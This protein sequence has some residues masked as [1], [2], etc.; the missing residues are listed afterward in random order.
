VNGIASRIPA[1]E[2]HA[3]EGL[4]ISRLKELKRSPKHYQWALTHPKESQPLTL[5]SAAH[6]AVLEPERF[7]KDY[8]V[9]ARRTDGGALAPR[10]GQWWDAFKAEHGNRT[11]ITADEYE[12]VHGLQGAVRADPVASRY[13]SSGE[14]EVVLSWTMAGRACRGRVDWLTRID[15]EPCIVGLKTARDC[16]PFIFGSAAAKLGYALQ[17]AWYF[18]G[19]VTVAGVKPRM[20]EIVVESA[21]P[22]AVV[23]Y[24][25][26]EDIIL[27]GEEE[28][29]RLLTQLSECEAADSWPGP[30]SVEQ[31]LTLPSWYYEVED[32]VSDLG[33]EAS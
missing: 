26:P 8:A 27:Q 16:R 17:W 2:Y 30:A 24:T 25:I 7:S 5:G 1:A 11:I 28:Y 23:V 18:N 12:T 14:P 3:S 21:A 33:L 31:V 10:R 20:V 13:L 32:D 19:Y 4:S 9:W 15:E 6:C 29:M 22:H